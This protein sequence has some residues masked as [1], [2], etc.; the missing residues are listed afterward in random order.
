M[1]PG[2]K[3]VK[4]CLHACALGFRLI[5]VSD[6]RWEN[7]EAVP[8]PGFRRSDS[9]KTQVPGSQS[10]ELIWRYRGGGGRVLGYRVL[11]IP[12]GGLGRWL[13]L[14]AGSLDDGG[15]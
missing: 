6:R 14:I 11:E 9:G 4:T 7:M 15:G 8:G 12:G 5:V 3:D 2:T 1:K 13:T 10:R